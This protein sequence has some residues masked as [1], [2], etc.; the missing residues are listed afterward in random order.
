MIE[1]GW[2]MIGRGWPKPLMMLLPVVSVLPR[3]TPMLRRGSSPL[4][5]RCAR[6]SRVRRA[7]HD[8]R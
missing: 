4:W 8:A 5:Q 3:P 7:S 1:T 2:P 6:Q